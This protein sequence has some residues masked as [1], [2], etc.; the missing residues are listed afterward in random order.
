LDKKPLRS[1]EVYVVEG[2]TKSGV[3]ITED[4]RS[5]NGSRTLHTRLYAPYPY[6]GYDIENWEAKLDGRK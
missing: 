3:S 5:R 4:C 2:A 1:I 6:N